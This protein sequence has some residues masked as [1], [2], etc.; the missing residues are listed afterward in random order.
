[1][2]SVSLEFLSPQGDGV[3][4]KAFQTSDCCDSE[5]LY[6][7]IGFGV[8]AAVGIKPCRSFFNPSR[9]FSP[10]FLQ[11]VFREDRSLQRRLSVT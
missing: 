6:L 9:A 4:L 1:M 2:L 5:V 7:R 3:F 10:H 11:P 8:S